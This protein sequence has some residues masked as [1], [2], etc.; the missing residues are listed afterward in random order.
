VSADH[1]LRWTVVRLLSFTVFAFVVTALVATTL[2]DLHVGSTDSYRALFTNGSGLQPGD[3]V[4]IAGVEVGRVNG[5]GLDG[6]DAVVSFSVNA[7]QHL[8]T[9]TEAQ[10]HF[11]NLLGQRFLDIVAG[12]NGGAPLHA[13]AT[14]PV[15]RTMP[16]LDLTSVFN[17]F[18]PL[19]SALSPGQVNQ[20]T[21]SIIQVFQGQAGT[22]NDL[23][24]QV[25]RLTSN[26]A[27]RQVVI[28]EVVDNLSGLV[29]SVGAHDE[30]LGQL[31]D[32]FTGLVHGLASERPAIASTISGVAQLNSGVSHVLAESQPDLDQS[33][34]G[35]ASVS[36]TL[37]RNQS[38]LDATLRD[39]P[40]FVSTLTKVVSSGNYI[41]VYV[42]NLSVQTQGTLDISLVPGVAA[43]QAGDPVSIPS[44]VVGDDAEH[45][46]N[47]G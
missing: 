22:F 45:T 38:A 35:L 10:I 21:G 19:F 8:T 13:G 42:C 28:D 18:Q 20:L 23:V 5:V 7:D 46:A 32:S 2:L 3:T 43:P 1:K 40:A 25:A 9:T 41:S 14:I 44:G 36:T 29:R 11:E 27:G 39:F 33:I 31:I 26:L 30:H 12:A 47:C 4:R 16:A 6:N 17:G 37:E 24:D 15:D 34:S